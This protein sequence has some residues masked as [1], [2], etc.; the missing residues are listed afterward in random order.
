[1]VEYSSEHWEGEGELDWPGIDRSIVQEADDVEIGREREAA[2]N[3]AQPPESI[4]RS[5]PLKEAPTGGGVVARRWSNV[6]RGAS[7]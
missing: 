1:M 5:V 7:E 4:V 3:L 6:G 2:R